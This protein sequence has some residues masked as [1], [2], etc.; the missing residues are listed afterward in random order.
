MS[1]GPEP[2]VEV[3]QTWIDPETCLGWTV[4]QIDT[5]GGITAEAVVE[6]A[7]C[8]AYDFA[9]DMRLEVPDHG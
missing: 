6:R 8:D 1:L 2:T 7:Y 4:T 5:D 3:G 9:R